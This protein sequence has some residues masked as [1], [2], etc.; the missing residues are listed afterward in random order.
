LQ[1][2]KTLRRLPPSQELEGD[3][4]QGKLELLR[5]CDLL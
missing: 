4:R 3:P 5:G 2:L 1:A